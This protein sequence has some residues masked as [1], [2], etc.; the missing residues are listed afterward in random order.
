M[1]KEKNRKN[2]RKNIT[3]IDWKKPKSLKKLLMK[4]ENILPDNEDN[5]VITFE[6]TWTNALKKSK[7]IRRLYENY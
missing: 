6:I 2:V 3:C 4:E 1:K 7:T 5:S